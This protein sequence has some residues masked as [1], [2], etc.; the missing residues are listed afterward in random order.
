M[1]AGLAKRF[2][3]SS[4]MDFFYE[5]RRLFV[6]LVVAN[7]LLQFGH[8][9]WS[10]TFNNYAVERLAVEADMVGWIQS[11]REVPGLLA[12]GLAVLAL[13]LSELRIVALSIVL[14]GLG[15][16]LT[17]QASSL[18]M[19][20]IATI[21]M[22]F[23]FHFFGPAAGSALMMGTAKEKA[24]RILGWMRT[25]GAIAGVIGTIAISLL[26]KPMGYPA[27][28][29]TVG[30]IVIAGGVLLFRLGS[31][32]HKLRSSARLDSESGTGSSTFSPTSRGVDDTSSRRSRPSSSSRTS[33]SLRLLWRTCF[34]RTLSSTSWPIS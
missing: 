31:G 3:G 9:I 23:G 22:S 28:F 12:I 2:R 26:V 24:P 34:W 14:L 16:L 8:R 13:F 29:L 33:M 30:G 1:V 15:I 6:F 17:G 19:L 25:I 7:F 11:A 20:F 18:P 10:A 32:G 5:N 27:F 21:I 4:L